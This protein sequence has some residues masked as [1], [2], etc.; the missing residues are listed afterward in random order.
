MFLIFN[1]RG[2]LILLGSVAPSIVAPGYGPSWPLLAGGV[3][4][5]GIDL[6]KRLRL[7]ESLKTCLFSPSAGGHI[8]YLPVWP[9][10]LIELCIA[11]TLL[12]SG[13]QQAIEEDV[14]LVVANEISGDEELARTIRN[15]LVLNYPA[16]SWNVRTT[17]VG[18][19]RVVFV[20]A[21]G[22]DASRLAEHIAQEIRESIDGPSIV[23]ILKRTASLSWSYPKGL[24][25]G[26]EIAQA[27]SAVDRPFPWLQALVGTI[28]CG[29]LLGGLW[30][31][32]KNVHSGGEVE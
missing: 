29:V 20:Y 27:Y 21:R 10:G 14:R 31:I 2:L 9:F 5:F 15:S 32:R 13:P 16:G 7:D 3:I 25:G 22:A 19:Q 30:A 28:V 8:Y 23:G 12:F 6:S 1:W 4:A 26:G 18:E 11:M 17:M 24:N